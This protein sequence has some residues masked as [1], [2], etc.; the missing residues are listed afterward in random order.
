MVVKI[1]SPLLQGSLQGMGISNAILHDDFGISRINKTKIVWD[2]IGTESR[3]NI[4]A[5]YCGHKMKHVKF[6]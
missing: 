3:R 5:E 2:M 1:I 6:I 4:Q